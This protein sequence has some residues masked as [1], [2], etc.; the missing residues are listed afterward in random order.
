MSQSPFVEYWTEQDTTDYPLQPCQSCGKE[1][2]IVY[3]GMY[4]QTYCAGT[5][6]PDQNRFVSDGCCMRG[7]GR[8]TKK[9]AADVWNQIQFIELRR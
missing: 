3:H 6:Y 5:S 2:K 8:P 9:A 4:S 7:P 1:A